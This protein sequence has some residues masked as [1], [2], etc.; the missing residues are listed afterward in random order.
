MKTRC[1]WVHLGVAVAALAAVGAG[2][3]RADDFQTSAKYAYV[4]D[5]N[6]GAVLLDKG[7]EQRMPPSGIN[8]EFLQTIEV[9][10]A[11]PLRMW[12]EK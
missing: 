5:A 7:G 3:A 8:A 9:L 6:T 2:A 4:I 11:R 10:G 12:R 1:R